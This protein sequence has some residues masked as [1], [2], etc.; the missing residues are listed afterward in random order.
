[1]LCFRLFLCTVRIVNSCDTVVSFVAFSSNTLTLPFRLPSCFSCLISCKRLHMPD[2]WPPLTPTVQ[3][4]RKTQAA[5]SVEFCVRRCLAP[6]LHCWYSAI[7]VPLFDACHLA[8]HTI[9]KTTVIC[10]NIVAATQTLTPVLTI[11]ISC[12][13]VCGEPEYFVRLLAL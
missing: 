2:L 13:Y 5:L 7:F 3:M 4:E 9:V 1:M 6:T 10:I 12:M 8:C 11:H